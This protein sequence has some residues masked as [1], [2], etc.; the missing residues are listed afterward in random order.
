VLL[1]CAAFLG[2]GQILFGPPSKP[3]PD[4]TVVAVTAL[5]PVLVA[6]R[7]VEAPGVA[8]AVCGAYL[9]PASTVALLLPSVAP[10]PLLLAPAIAFDVALW[11][12]PSHLLALLPRRTSRKRPSPGQPSMLR[13]SLA[14]AAFGVV[15]T[16]VEVPFRIFLGGD[17]TAWSGASELTAAAASAL[18]CGA[19]A[20]LLTVRGTAS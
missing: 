1:A 11:L 9:L 12:Q 10:P 7:V 14:G 20:R 6:V 13:A 17:P 16:T 5:L 15:L 4:L 3:I 2:V 8:S 19:L 18:A